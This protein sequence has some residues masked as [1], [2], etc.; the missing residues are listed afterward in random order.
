[1]NNNF[2]KILLV[3]DDLVDADLLVNLLE[4]VPSIQFDMIH[5]KRLQEAIAR[6]GGEP[7]DVVLLDLSLPDSQGVDTVKKM[8]QRSPTVPIVILSGLEDQS[9]ALQAVQNGAQDYLVKGEFE[10]DLLVR[11]IRY[12]IERGK[13]LQLLNQKEKELQKA[14]EELEMRVRIRTE[15]LQ[16]K[17]VQLQELEVQLRE[18]LAKEKELSD[19]KSRI[20]TTI[21]HEYRTP[22]TTIASS[23]ELLQVY[24]HRWDEEKQ[25]KHYRRIKE[26]VKHMT[27]LVDDVLFVNQA[28]FY[29]LELQRSPLHL[30]NFVR[31][32][33]E[34]MQ[35]AVGDR[36]TLNLISKVDGRQVLLDPKLLRQIITNLLSNG[37]KYSPDGGTVEV[38]LIGEEERIIVEV[39][40]RGIGI[41]IE[42]RKHLFES[43]RRA[44]NVGTIR[45]TGLGLS[46]VKKCIDIHG[47]QISVESEVGTGT[48]FTVVLPLQTEEK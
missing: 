9:V 47:G 26:S 11:A 16:K 6:L 39:S 37:I 45:G 2:I 42:D 14:N 1:M 32:L 38:K 3:E 41:P 46:I 40:D 10:S 28:E 17:N 35:A 21:S 4:L 23:A 33:V 5:V 30:G 31:E 24:R 36:P 8:Y 27:A 48:T 20:I 19:L 22:L 25:M 7:F 12:A 44:S 43:F 15:E 34:D 18:A 13:I 29:K